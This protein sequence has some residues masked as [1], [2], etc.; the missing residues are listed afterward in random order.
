MNEKLCQFS[1]NITK[2]ICFLKTRI[3]IGES[4]EK[5]SRKF[6]TYLKVVGHAVGM[7]KLLDMAYRQSRL[8][9]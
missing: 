2:G 1:N 4:L 3:Q 5:I 6:Q 9:T 7:A 8:A